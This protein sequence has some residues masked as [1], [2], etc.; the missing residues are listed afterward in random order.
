MDR[1]SN[2]MQRLV[3]QVRFSAEARHGALTQIR[4]ATRAT[5][6]RYARERRDMAQAARGRARGRVSEI[7]GAAGELRHSTRLVLGGIASDVL[8]ATRLWSKTSMG[9]DF[10]APAATRVEE[11]P[12]ATGKAASAPARPAAATS[13]PEPPNKPS[14]SERVLGIIQAHEDGVRL[15]DIGNAL[16]VDWR[17]L[18]A[19][20]KSLL[21]EGTVEKIDSLYYPVED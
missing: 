13:E 12:A 10:A 19:V 2:A 14:E 11:K 4:S 17:G 1:L 5:L 20:T 7:R 21:E 3:E 15:V 18:I 16:G 9:G 6:A 8:A